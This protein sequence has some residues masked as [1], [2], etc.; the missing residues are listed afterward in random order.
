MAE[1]AAAV[2]AERVVAVVVAVA[3]VVAAV[4]TKLVSRQPISI[5]RLDPASRVA[6]T[7]RTS[8]TGRRGQIDRSIGQH[9]HSI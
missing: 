2:V 7:A 8:P 6:V 3:M 4:C 9:A 5:A 1:E